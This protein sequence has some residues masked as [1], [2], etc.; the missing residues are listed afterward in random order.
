[1]K[2]HSAKKK[3]REREEGTN[4]YYTW[5]NFKN[6]LQVQAA[7]P[8]CHRLGGLSNIHFSQVWK[9]DVQDQGVSVVGSW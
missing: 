3:K 6:L 4:T 8:K 5:M 7:V 9:L 2:Y 1:M